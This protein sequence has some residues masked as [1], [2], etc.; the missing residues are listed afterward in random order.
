M[1]EE[2]FEIS[3]EAA[4]KINRARRIVATGTT[5]V[6]VLESSTGTDGKA[7]AMTGHTDLFIYPGY[8]FKKVDCLLTNFHLPRSSLFLLV[9]AFAG[10]ELIDKAYTMAIE[11]GFRFYSYGD[12]MLIL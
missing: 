5:A 7:R 12:C 2:Y 1:E 4:E 10:K 8:R 9:C 3:G 6:R 11:E